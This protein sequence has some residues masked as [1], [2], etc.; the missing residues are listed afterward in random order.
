MKA[1][2][3]FPTINIKILARFFTINVL[4]IRYYNIT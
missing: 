2:I 4:I 1:V 3:I